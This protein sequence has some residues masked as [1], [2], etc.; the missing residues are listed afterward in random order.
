MSGT[1]ACDAN[2]GVNYVMIITYVSG[3]N[4]NPMRKR[5]AGIN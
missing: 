4:G 2:S 1:L 5:A 3:A